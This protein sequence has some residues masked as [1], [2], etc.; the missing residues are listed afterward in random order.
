MRGNDQLAEPSERHA[1]I[2]AQET[3]ITQASP[4]NCVWLSDFSIICCFALRHRQFTSQQVE[5]RV[6]VDGDPAQP[7]GELM[8]HDSRRDTRGIDGAA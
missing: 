1:L 7:A 8:N 4:F 6:K 5:R 2:P 3:T